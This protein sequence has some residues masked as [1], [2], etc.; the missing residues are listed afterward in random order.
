[1]RRP[2]KYKQQDVKP[3]QTRIKRV[4]AF[5]PTVVG[6]FILWLEWYE[7]LE[8]YIQEDFVVQLDGVSQGFRLEHWRMI[9]KRLMDK[10]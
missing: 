8:G 7:Q 5:R 9:S 3:G 10:K 1:M 6:D 2:L 4:F